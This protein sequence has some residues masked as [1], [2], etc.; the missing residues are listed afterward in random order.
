MYLR[1]HSQM[2]EQE[3]LK[4]TLVLLLLLPGHLFWE[5]L[6]T[7]INSPAPGGSWVQE[8]RGHSRHAGF[9]GSHCEL[10]LERCA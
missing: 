8:E 10:W 5:G 6:L 1:S 4:E 2:K 7:G 3:F 9:S